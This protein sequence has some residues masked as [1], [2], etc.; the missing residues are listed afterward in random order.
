MISSEKSRIFRLRRKGRLGAQRR[1]GCQATPVE[2]RSHAKIAGPLRSN[3]VRG[4]R[5]THK[6]A[7]PPLQCLVT[8]RRKNPTRVARCRLICCLRLRP[9]GGVVNHGRA[10]HEPIETLRRTCGCGAIPFPAK[11]ERGVWACGLWQGSFPV[12]PG[13]EKSKAQGS[14]QR[15]QRLTALRFARDSP[16]DESPETEASVHWPAGLSPNCPRGG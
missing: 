10:R 9:F 16:A 5:P 7:C 2:L 11:R 3:A 8:T 14:I 13:G 6:P 4:E 15:V 12:Y 1:Q